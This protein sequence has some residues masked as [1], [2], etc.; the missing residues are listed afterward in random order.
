M[1]VDRVTRS[2]LFCGAVAALL[3][4]FIAIAGARQPA[5]A[6]VT[7]DKDD[8]GGVVTSAKG[9]EAGVR[10]NAETSELPTKMAK[11]AVTDDRGRHV[12]PD[13]PQATYSVWVRG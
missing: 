12:I 6:A 5:A 3:A 11:I 4:S 9:P 2:N 13:L 8:I 10:V 7:V 1:K